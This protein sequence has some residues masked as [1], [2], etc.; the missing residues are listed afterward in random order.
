MHR[1]FQKNG[2]LTSIKPLNIIATIQA[3]VSIYDI[4][5]SIFRW[6]VQENYLEQKDAA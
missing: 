6:I 4:A 1:L 5:L 3:K 2:W